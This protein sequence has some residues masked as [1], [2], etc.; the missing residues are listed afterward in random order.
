MAKP[1]EDLAFQFMTVV[2]PEHRGHRLGI[3]IKIANLQQVHQHEQPPRRI[4]T[5]NGETNAEMVRVNE[6]LGFVVAGHA[7]NWQKSLAR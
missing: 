2:A 6:E 7:S 4:C 5:W 3:L 1:G